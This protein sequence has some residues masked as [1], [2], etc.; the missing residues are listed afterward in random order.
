MLPSRGLCARSCASRVP[1]HRKRRFAGELPHMPSSP[2]TGQ[3]RGFWH[4]A[5]DKPITRAEGSRVSQSAESHTSKPHHKRGIWDPSMMQLLCWWSI[6]KQLASATAV[7][8]GILYTADLSQHSGKIIPPDSRRY[9]SSE[10]E[11]ITDVSLATNLQRSS[12]LVY[13]AARKE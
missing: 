9:T 8:W 2:H 4:A 3:S 10:G 1:Q 6:L 11:S 12:N 5:H 7:R 13:E